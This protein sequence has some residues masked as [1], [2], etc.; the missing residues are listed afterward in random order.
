MTS[1]DFILLSM[2]CFCFCFFVFKHFCSQVCTLVLPSTQHNLKNSGNGYE[3]EQQWAPLS[4]CWGL[5][6]DSWNCAAPDVIWEKRKV[7]I[8]VSYAKW[9]M[10]SVMAPVWAKQQRRHR[11]ASCHRWSFYH[12]NPLQPLTPAPLLSVHEC[13]TNAEK[14]CLLSL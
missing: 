10:L 5:W 11:R 6:F 7:H 1:K 3:T 2:F 14:K 4:P 9:M 8:H 13:I 12:P